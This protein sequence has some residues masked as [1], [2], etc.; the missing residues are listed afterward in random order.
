[1]GDT[2]QAQRLLHPV[3]HLVFAQ[4]KVHRTKGDVLCDVRAEQLVVRVLQHQLD[5][6]PVFPQSGAVMGQRTSVDQHSASGRT[7]RP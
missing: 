3:A 5:V 4:A 6:T 1:M 2:E 7:M